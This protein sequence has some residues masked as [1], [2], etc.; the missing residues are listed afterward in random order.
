M[1][2]KIMNKNF[3]HFIEFATR[4]E[5]I[6]DLLGFDPWHNLTHSGYDI[7]PPKDIFDKRKI[8]SLIYRASKPLTELIEELDKAILWCQ[9][10]EEEYRKKMEYDNSWIECPDCEGTPSDGY[11]STCNDTGQINILDFKGMI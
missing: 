4:A 10:G 8:E 6:Y 7:P 3:R 11:C 5:M 2:T 9:L 1:E